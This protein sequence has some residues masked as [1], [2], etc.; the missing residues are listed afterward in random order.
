MHEEVAK[1]EE[2]RKGNPRPTLVN[3]EDAKK[4]G[5]PFGQDREDRQEY[6]PDVNDAIVLKK[7]Q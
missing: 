5:S 2:M 3:E 7:E 4:N 1:L 6:I